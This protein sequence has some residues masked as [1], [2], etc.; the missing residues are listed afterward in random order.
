[1]DL[2]FQ[3]VFAKCRGAVTSGH[4]SAE[5][6]SSWSRRS[7]AQHAAIRQLNRAPMHREP[8]PAPNR[9]DGTTRWR[10]CLSDSRPGSKLQSGQHRSLPWKEPAYD[11]VV[12]SYSGARGSESVCKFTTKR[13]RSLGRPAG[14]PGSTF[15][16]LGCPKEIESYLPPQGHSSFNA[17]QGKSGRV[18][19][20][21][22]WVRPSVCKLSSHCRQCAQSAFGQFEDGPRSPLVV[23]RAI[24]RSR[25][26]HRSGSEDHRRPEARLRGQ[27]DRRL[28]QVVCNRSSIH[29]AIALHRGWE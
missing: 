16:A 28:C 29:S 8:T 5:R 24:S 17:P 15:A 26:R 18:H 2:A 6:A 25:H 13:R 3:H 27:L 20:P 11:Y 22:D 19:C 21:D 9:N 1:M 23:L 4:L 10:S 14:L 7:Q 12:R